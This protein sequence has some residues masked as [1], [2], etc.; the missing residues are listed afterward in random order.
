MNICFLAP[1]ASKNTIRSVQME[2][3]KRRTSRFRVSHFSAEAHDVGVCSFRFEL[4]PD[5]SRR[6][7]GTD[8]CK[9]M[10]IKQLTGLIRNSIYYSD[11]SGSRN[12]GKCKPVG[13]GWDLFFGLGSSFFRS[14]R[15][16][17]HYR[18]IR[19][20]W[21]RLNGAELN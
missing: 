12:G 10:R 19:V 17:Y 7:T 20:Q 5:T 21:A 16:H 18:F 3:G 9:C 6:D 4:I 8:W 1:C 15:I 11:E 14:D 13:G 2:E